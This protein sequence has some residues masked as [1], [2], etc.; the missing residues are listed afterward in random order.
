MPGPKQDT[1]MTAPEG[2]RSG[3]VLSRISSLL[4][5]DPFKDIPTEEEYLATRAYRNLLEATRSVPP[6]KRAEVRGRVARNLIKSVC[7]NEG[8]H[9]QAV[10]MWKVFHRRFP[11][12]VTDGDYPSGSEL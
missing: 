5:W 11:K 3:G 6:G 12:Y 8:D 7:E 4:R 9:K 1:Q 2:H 10:E